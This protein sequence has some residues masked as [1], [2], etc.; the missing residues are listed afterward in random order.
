[1]QCSSHFFWY[2]GASWKF[3]KQ[4]LFSHAPCSI[5][6]HMTILCTCIQITNG[7]P[8]EAIVQKNLWVLCETYWLRHMMPQCDWQHGSSRQTLLITFRFFDKGYGHSCFW[9]WLVYVRVHHGQGGGRDAP[10][11]DVW[12]SHDRDS[13]TSVTGGYWKPTHTDRYLHYQLY[14][15]L[16]WRMAS[17]QSRKVCHDSISLNQELAQLTSVSNKMDTLA[18]WSA[19]ITQSPQIWTNQ[20]QKQQS[21]FPLSKGSVKGSLPKEEYEF[22]SGQ[23]ELLTPSWA[24]SG[25]RGTPWWQGCDLPNPLL[26]LWQ[27]LH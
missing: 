12:V 16:L 10:F 13:N 24:T 26:G 18:T 4:T 22:I 1:M 27:I 5:C 15:P 20:N 11:L 7:V 19:H 3:D 9:L 25:Q 23:V 2:Q 8:S 6:F 21:P 14:Q 17:A